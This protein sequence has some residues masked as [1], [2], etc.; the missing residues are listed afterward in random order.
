MMNMKKLIVI[1]ML[2][3][4]TVAG[5]ATGPTKYG[6]IR[7]GY[8]QLS[9]PM[10]FTAADSTAG[11]G[12]FHILTADSLVI[13]VTNLQKYLQYQTFTTTLGYVSGDH[14]V[15]IT[16]YGKVTSNDSWH[17]IGSAVSWISTSSNPGIITGSTPVNYNYFRISYVASGSTQ[18]VKVLTF[19]VKTSNAYEMPTSGGT[20]TFSR[21]T[22]GTV[23][24]NCKNDNANAALTVEAGGTGALTLGNGTGTAAMNSS[25]WDISTTGAM[26]GIGAITMDGKLTAGAAIDLVGPINQAITGGTVVTSAGLLGGGGTATNATQTLGSAGGKAF[27]YYLSST[28]TTASHVLTGYYMNVNYGA[29]GG[30]SAAP[31]G[32]VI[33]GRA[34][35]MGDASGTSALTG[36]AFSVELEAYTASNTGLTAGM[37]GNLVLPAGVLTNA[38]TYY[39]TMAE[40][41]LGGASTDTRAYTEIAPLGII[42]GGTAATSAAQLSNMV[43]IAIDVPANMVTSDATMVVTG[44]T[45]AV[46]AGLK[47]SINGTPYWIMLATQD[48]P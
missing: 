11:N 2:A 45:G 43:A 17:P 6:V 44:A 27:S 38:G 30:A 19:E 39:G 25:D 28:S 46:A 1:L 37:R 8:T 31:S 34:Y 41:F 3:I 7:T 4:L 48:E 47:I 26:T 5:M 42:V 40:V 9:K 12:G 14:V 13:L 29:T 22:S 36:G 15:T 18:C 33:R 10:A 16:A 24:L 35:L 23:T 21:P 20:V 32:D